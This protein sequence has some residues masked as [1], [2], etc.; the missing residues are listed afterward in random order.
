MSVTALTAKETP[1]GM[2]KSEYETRVALAACARLMAQYRLTDLTNGLIAARLPDEPDMCLV[3]RYGEFFDE[4]TATSLVK[5]PIR[6]TDGIEVGVDVNHAAIPLFQSVFQARPEI[7]AMVHAHTK[8]TEVL[9]TL[10]CKIEPISHPGLMLHNRTGYAG[11]VYEHDEAFCQK[12]VEGLEGNVCM[13]LGNHGMIA[14]GRNVAESFFNTYSF[15]QACVIQLEA[16]QTGR[17]ICYP[18][19]IEE[20]TECYARE[21][22]EGTDWDGSLE[23]AG[24][25]RMMDRKDPSFR[26]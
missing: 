19:F 17:E 26:N 18:N 6:G 16:Y 8:A 11:Y 4:I 5:M 24:W 12:M 2:T 10:G 13:L 23:W 25:L 14:L 9:S 21:A 20:S 3:N 15:D 7:N 22:E 1:A